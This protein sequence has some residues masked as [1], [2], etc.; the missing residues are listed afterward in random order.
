MA[1]LQQV[2][3]ALCARAELGF[4][5]EAIFKLKIPFLF[6]YSVST[7][8]KLQKFISKSSELQKL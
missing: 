2:E 8:F 4:G 7:D 5:P 3:R 6:F 1:E